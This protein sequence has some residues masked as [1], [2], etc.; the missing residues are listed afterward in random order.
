MQPLGSLHPILLCWLD[1]WLRHFLA[2]FL[3]MHTPNRP[4]MPNE[5]TRMELLARNI[6]LL[7]LGC[8]TTR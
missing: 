6:G 3:L 1:S 4:L 2:C 5:E 7:Q 8:V